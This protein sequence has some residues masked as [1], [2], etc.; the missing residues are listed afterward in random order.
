[1]PVA[2]ITG[3]GGLIGSE[4]VEHFI[5]EGFDVVGIENDMR[6]RFFGPES[7]TS[8]V[9][10]RLVAEHPEFRWEEADIRDAERV[11]AIFAEHAGQIELVVHTA[12]QPSHDWA[13]SDP[14]TDFGVN[15]NGTLNLLEAARAHCP[16]APFVFCSTN[17]V[18]GDT[19][20]RLPLQSLE[21][22]LELP[23]DHPYYKGID[24]SMSIDSS[25]HSLFGVSKAA[26]DLLVQEYGYYFEM[27]T[28]CFRG[29]CLTG[30]QHAGA[31]LHG[32]LAYLM[33]CT[34]TGTPYTVFGYEG[35]Q[36]RDNIH[37]ADLIAAFDAFR[38]APRPHAVYNIGG[39]RF[40]NCSMLEAI[41]ACERI[42]GRE[43]AVGDGRGAADRRPPL[44]DLRPRAVPGRLPGLRAAL[45]DRRHPA[46]DA[47]AEPRALDGERRVKL[48]VVMPAQNEEGSV[49][50]TVEGVVAALEGAEIDYEVVVVNDDSEDS[51]E[52]VVAAIGESN[53]RVRVHRSHLE[54]GFG[55]AIRAGLDVFEGDAVAIVM[56]DAS[57]SPADLVTYHRVLEEGWDCAFGSRFMP[58]ARI[59]DYPRLKYAFNRLA[60]Q[61][62]R[63]LFRHR[64]NDTT[65]AFKAYRREVIETIQPLLSK[66]FNLTVEMP[67][68]AVVRGHSFKVVPTDWTNRTSG[69]AKLAMKEMGSRYLFIVLYVW[70][71]SALSRGDYRVQEAE[72]RQTPR[73]EINS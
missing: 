40:S 42:A 67:L 28:V 33:K 13:A 61:F 11:A 69:E 72:R 2:I 70:L 10:E 30:P 12:A 17:K 37:S 34:V 52:A 26:A 8:H 64:Y 23:E 41:D 16:D 25:T 35:K 49:G 32:F 3:A 56:A 46:R 55:N 54:R 57:D 6:A 24:T 7:S 59:H 68:K 15:A 5:T 36:V 63:L 14:Q 58:G 51:T 29:G 21:K 43:L 66:H 73:Q 4:A 62:I 60:N 38:K 50:A 47:R 44:V 39:G 9:T 19:P 31:K 53:P 71:E 27:P 1:M 18:Y 45:R 20:N 65:N 48:S 22:R